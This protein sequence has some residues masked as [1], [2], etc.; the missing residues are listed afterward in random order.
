MEILNVKGIIV[1][2]L[3]FAGFV[4]VLIYFLSRKQ[5]TYGLLKYMKNTM[6]FLET[7][8]K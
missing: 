2:G 3:L 4:C 6:F 8:L 5:E 7:V 1:L